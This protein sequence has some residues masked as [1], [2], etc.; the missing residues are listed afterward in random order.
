[1]EEWALRIRAA[2]ARGVESG[3]GLRKL[4]EQIGMSESTLGRKLKGETRLRPYEREALIR[5]VAEATALPYEFFTESFDRMRHA[6]AM[7]SELQ[8]D[9]IKRLLA[10]HDRVDAGDVTEAEIAEYAVL[11]VRGSLGDLFDTYMKRL[12][13][14]LVEAG[15]LAADSPALLPTYET[16]EDEGPAV[17]PLPAGLR[18]RAQA[19]SP[20]E[21][22]RDEPSTGE[23]AA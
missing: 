2:A 19:Q 6:P 18:R 21:P 5:Q 10:L 20:T 3:T 7:S 9:E 17:P 16:A 12:R 8:I 15:V 22:A 4:A 13:E 11:S 14:E 1:M 23:G